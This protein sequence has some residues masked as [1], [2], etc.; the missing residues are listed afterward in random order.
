M[1]TEAEIVAKIERIKL[2]FRRVSRYAERNN[3]AVLFIKARKELYRK[4]QILRD[5]VKDLLG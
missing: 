1:M 5:E 2:R 4:T 3:N